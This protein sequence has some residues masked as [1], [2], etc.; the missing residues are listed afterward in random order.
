[1]RH[2][3]ASNFKWLALTLLMSERL[4]L[5][6]R[7]RMRSIKQSKPSLMIWVCTFRAAQTSSNSA[8]PSSTSIESISALICLRLACTIAICSLKQAREPM[9][10]ARHSVSETSQ[11][12]SAYCSRMASVTSRLEIVPSKSRY[13]NASGCLCLVISWF[14]DLKTPPL[15]HGE[16][17][18]RAARPSGLA[19]SVR[20]QSKE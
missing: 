9:R 18:D 7:S 1:M 6:A 15:P 3:C 11:S 19:P 20:K 16:V 2:G 17:I 13:S 14:G 12:S 8:K 10:P 5:T 4:P